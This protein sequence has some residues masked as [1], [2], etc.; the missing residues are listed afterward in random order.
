MFT[1]RARPIAVLISFLTL[2][3]VVAPVLAVDPVP[4]VKGPPQA[5]TIHADMLAEHEGDSLGFEPGGEPAALAQPDG[6]GG[7]MSLDSGGTGGIAA[8][9]NSLNHEVYGYLPYWA[10][11]SAQ[12]ANLDYELLSSIAYFSVGAA[13]DGTLGKSSPGWSGW[14]SSAMTEVISKAHQHGV[15]VVLTVTMMAWNYNFTAMSTLLNSA[16][17]RDRLATEIASAVKARNADGVNLDF[18]PMPNSL[19]AQYTTFVRKVKSEL[20]RLGAGSYLTVATT[21]GAASWDE[22]YDLAG[23][24]ASGAADALMVMAYDFNWGGSARAGGVAPIDSPYVLD[25]RRAMRD[26]LAKVPGSK[27]IWG[28]PY[29]GRGWT[30]ETSLL[31]AKTCKSSSICPTGKA[32]AEP[33]GRSWAPRYV[34]ALEAIGSHGR[35]WDA[36]GQV[37]WYTYYSSTYGTHVQGYYDDSTSLKAKYG[38][39][40]A[41]DLRGVG[42]WHLTMDGSRRELWDT[43]ATQF[44]PLPFTDIID[45]KFVTDIIWLAESGITSG[46]SDTKFCPTAAVTRAQMATFLD[47]ALALPPATRD[48]FTDDDGNKH[49]GA[50]NRVAQ[51]GI[52]IGCGGT[53]YCPQGTVLRDQMASFLSRALGL[54]TTTRDHFTDDDGNRHEQAINRVAEADITHGCDD[55]RYCPKGVVLREQMAAFLRRADLGS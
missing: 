27:L 20:L 36:T 24:T 23:L 5:P 13:S 12:L 32:A 44:G 48:Y 3:S 47:R 21:G 17:N 51:A 15:R 18:E 40:R 37:P 29:Y 7:M 30:T 53:N 55:G 38:M 9:P 8:L 35:R 25:S 14:N 54:P 6:G 22:G 39:V 43:L 10:L 42:I 49:E 16:T 31:N 33:F 11:T 2:L 41:N 19:E 45:S 46:C 50:I 26:Y 28:V 34:D 4:D 52:T 1:T